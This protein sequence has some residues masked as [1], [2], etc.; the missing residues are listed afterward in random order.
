[1]GII[2]SKRLSVTFFG[3]TLFIVA[4][5]FQNCGGFKLGPNPGGFNKS[6]SQQFNEEEQHTDQTSLST[7]NGN[8]NQPPPPP[9]PHEHDKIDTGAPVDIYWMSLPAPPDFSAEN[10]P[11]KI[12]EK[13]RGFKA[14]D[15]SELVPSVENIDWLANGPQW[16]RVKLMAMVKTTNGRPTLPKRFYLKGLNQTECHQRL[17]IHSQSVPAAGRKIGEFRGTC[18]WEAGAPAGR[19]YA[20]VITLYGAS[21]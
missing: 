16:V 15:G 7:N 10:A 9:P 3:L 8:P 21:Q 14:V 17:V 5:L 13:L 12:A 2:K 11:A 20:A 4:L 19:E 1:M 18:T 6:P